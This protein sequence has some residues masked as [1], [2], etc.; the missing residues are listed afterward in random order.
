MTI[1]VKQFPNHQRDGANSAAHGRHDPRH[2]RRSVRSTE[3]IAG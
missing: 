1:F 2:N 3:R